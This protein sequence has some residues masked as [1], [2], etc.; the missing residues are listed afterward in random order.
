M[1]DV[2]VKVTK[3]YLSSFQLSCARLVFKVNVFIMYLPTLIVFPPL[4]T[5]VSS[6]TTKT[7]PTI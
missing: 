1:R 5:P 7:Q 2:V 3:Q 6:P 4:K